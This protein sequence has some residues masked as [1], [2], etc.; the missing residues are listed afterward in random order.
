M[1]TTLLKEAPP[2]GRLVVY[3]VPSQ[4]LDLIL[5]L[6]IK[7]LLCFVLLGVILLLLLLFFFF[8][9]LLEVC[10]HGSCCFPSF[11]LAAASVIIFEEFQKRSHD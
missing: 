9:L 8:S 3:C 10:I 2:S 1:V 5:F 11:S 7:L 4:L 6:R